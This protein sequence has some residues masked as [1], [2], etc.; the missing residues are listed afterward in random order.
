MQPGTE[1]SLGSALPRP[2]RGQAIAGPTQ[3]GGSRSA[4]YREHG[5]YRSPAN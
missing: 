5:Y 2:D 4:R 3:W 1:L